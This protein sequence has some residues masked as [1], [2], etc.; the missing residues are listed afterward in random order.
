MSTLSHLSD[1]EWGMLVKEVQQAGGVANLEGF[2]R[3]AI[4]TALLKAKSF[5]GDKSAAGRYA[6]NMRWQNRGAAA[7]A[8]PDDGDLRRRAA[9]ARWKKIKGGDTPPDS[10]KGP[11]K[12][13]RL[14]LAVTAD[15]EL[16]PVLDGDAIDP[17]D[18]AREAAKIRWDKMKKPQPTTETSE[19]R[20]PR[21]YVGGDAKTRAKAIKMLTKRTAILERDLKRVSRKKD[22]ESQAVARE[23]RLLLADSQRMLDAEVRADEM[24]RREGR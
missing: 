12:R 13:G 24:A 18:L 8:P 5:G 2:A 6:A 22:S 1:A 15:G 11:R 19:E 10:N 23:L 4:V 21:A 3:D 16:V 20:K 7:G 17:R 9:R 14:A